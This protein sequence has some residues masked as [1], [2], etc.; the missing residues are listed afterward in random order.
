MLRR[1]RPHLPAQGQT[2][3]NLSGCFAWLHLK[4]AGAKSQSR[5]MNRDIPGAGFWAQCSG[6][7]RLGLDGGLLQVW[8]KTSVQE[9]D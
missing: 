7:G 6:R 4:L 8:R 5:R 9:G 2:S 1:T 3:S